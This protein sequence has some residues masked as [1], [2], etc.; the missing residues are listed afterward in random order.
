MTTLRRQRPEPRAALLWLVLTVAPVVL[1]WQEGHASTTQQI[2]TDHHSGLAIHGYDPVAYFTDRAAKTGRADLEVSHA[3]VPW[4]FYNDGNR[5]AFARDPAVYMPQYGGHDPV[6]IAGKIARAGH[7]DFWAIHNDRLF[8][9]YS[10]DARTAF[11]A[12]PDHILL[13]AETNWPEVI[14]MLAP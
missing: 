1:L 11:R 14:R 3:G 10:E 2:V 4:R 8:L 13:E 12:D 9:F 5:Q 6:A 7:P